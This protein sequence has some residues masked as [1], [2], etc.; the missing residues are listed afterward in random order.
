MQIRSVC[1]S[2][3]STL[4][5]TKWS[6]FIPIC[7]YMKFV[8]NMYFSFLKRKSALTNK[9]LPNG[10]RSVGS[11]GSVNASGQPAQAGLGAQDEGRPHS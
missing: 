9:G 8:N 4:I 11:L 1:G 5:L 3:S 6:R 7:G 2:G 10:I